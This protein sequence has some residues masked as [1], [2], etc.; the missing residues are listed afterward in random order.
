MSKNN[1]RKAFDNARDKIAGVAVSGIFS[2]GV[3]AVGATMSLRR[4]FEQFTGNTFNAFS[5][6]AYNSR[7]PISTYR[8]DDVGLPLIRSKV[9]YR[10]K[11]HLSM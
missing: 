4:N 8:T 6:T 5:V 9:P 10:T 2:A 11:V 1:I 7:G 3:S